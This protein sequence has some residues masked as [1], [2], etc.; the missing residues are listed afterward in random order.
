MKR[1]IILFILVIITSQYLNAQQQAAY[2]PK[3][4][5]TIRDHTFTDLINNDKK[6]AS[7][8]DYRGQW[9]VLDV[10]TRF[11][12]GCINSF[13]RM[14]SLSK[15]FEGK[16]KIIMIGGPGQMRDL[17]DY[18]KTK[19]VYYKQQQIHNLT[20]TVAFDSTI[21]KLL[22]YLSTPFIVVI[23]PEGNI[24]A[25]TDHLEA[26]DLHSIIE[27][28]IP[29]HLAPQYSVHETR[30]DAIY[31]KKIPLFTSGKMEN[32]GNDTAYIFR[33]LITRW[34]PKMPYG[35]PKGFFSNNNTP[36]TTSEFW[37]YTLQHMLFFVYTGRMDWYPEYG[38]QNGLILETQK[39]KMSDLIDG[40]HTDN[41]YSYSITIP[42][43]N[44]N[45][46]KIRYYLSEDIEKT[47][48]ISTRLEERP[49]KTLSVVVK[50][51]GKLKQHKSKGGKSEIISSEY[52]GPFKIRNMKIKQWLEYTLSGNLNSARNKSGLPETFIEDNTSFEFPIDVDI[53]YGYM[54]FDEMVK[55]LNEIGLDVVEVEKPMKCIIVYDSSENE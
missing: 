12:A 10:W 32:G 8:K 33:S 53:D 21:Q 4:G 41:L 11:C 13:S 52:Q 2:Y 49:V 14:D 34:N 44:K 18:Q 29:D 50:D 5:E 37:G 42:E 15:E 6:S 23:N 45:L 16:A 38:I 54:K 26:K 25:K 22:D 1:I 35:I 31:N 48:G 20:F 3:V 17:N 46:K 55:K 19:A 51:I 30:P 24:V 7:I 43:I 27:G 9:L 39:W 36:S 47:F 40:P 28:K